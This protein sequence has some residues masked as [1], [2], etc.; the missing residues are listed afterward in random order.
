[1]V[2]GR[3]MP[4]I[5][6]RRRSQFRGPAGFTAVGLL[7]VAGVAVGLLAVDPF[8][9]RGPASQVEAIEEAVRDV[10]LAPVTVEHSGDGAASPEAAVTQFLDAM[11]DDDSVAA[12]ALLSLGGRALFATPESWAKQRLNLL[13]DITSW[14]WNEVPAGTRI[15]REPAVSLVRGIQPAMADVTWAT[16]DEDGWRIDLEASSLEAVLPPDE[17]AVDAAQRWLDDCPNPND[18]GSEA[19]LGSNP[20]ALDRACGDTI[21]P[22]T[23]SQPVTGRVA[24]DLMV[25]FGPTA[26]ELTRA[27]P[28]GNS[29]EVLIIVAPDIDDWFVIDVVEP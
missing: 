4:S 12:H 18:G 7:V 16:V 15:T 22:G 20:S 2:G 25:A 6:S 8:N 19:F 11:V 23:S 10:P 27:V 14:D 5:T 21:T 13:G 17:R 24:A 1:M 28:I 26:P 29:V 3:T 9:W